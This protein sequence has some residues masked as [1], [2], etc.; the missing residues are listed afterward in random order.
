MAIEVDDREHRPEPG[1]GVAL[2]TV[3]GIILTI[4]VLSLL[5]WALMVGV[6]ATTA[7]RNEQGVGSVPSGPLMDQRAAPA[8]QP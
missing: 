2:L 6:A 5:I 8:K 7:G 3:L 4:G 1:L